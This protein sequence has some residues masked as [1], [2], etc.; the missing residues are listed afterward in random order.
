MEIGY[1]LSS[2][3]QGKGIMTKAVAAMI[4]DAFKNLGMN[5]V[6]IHCASGNLRSRA[7]PA[8]LGFTQDG[9][10]REGGLLNGKFVDKVIYSML[11]SE[12][13]T[14]DQS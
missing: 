6:E 3:Q 11:A 12:W 5:R 14:H 8:R 4:D 10:M 2:G 7:I 13:K 1:W 9:V